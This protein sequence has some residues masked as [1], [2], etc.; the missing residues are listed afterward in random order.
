[1]VGTTK[2]RLSHAVCSH[3]NPC[4]F[5]LTMIIII[6]NLKWIYYCNHGDKMFP[7]HTA[8]LMQN[9]DEVVFVPRSN[10]TLFI[11]LPHLNCFVKCFARYFEGQWCCCDKSWQMRKCFYV[12]FWR[13]WTNNKCI[14]VF[15]F[16][17]LLVLTDKNL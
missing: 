8:F 11:L 16:E 15:H 4:W 1:M 10:Q 7:N 5:L 17:D 12:S 9:Y 13:A 2:L 3:F 14:L 6:P